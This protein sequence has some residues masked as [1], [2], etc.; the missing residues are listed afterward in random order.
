MLQSESK[1]RPGT[2]RQVAIEATNI[3][4][5]YPPSTKAV[6]NV[7]F[8]VHDGEVFGLLGPNGAGKTTTIKMITT[9]SKLTSGQITVFGNDVRTSPENVRSVLGYVPQGVSVDVDLT[10]YENLLIFAKLFYVDRKDRSGRIKE[11]LEYMGLSERANDLVKKF[12]GGMMRRLEIAQTL[13]NRPRI[14]FLDEPSIGLDPNSRLHVWESIKQLK[15]NYGTTIF[16]TTHDMN[17]A[18]ELCDRVA[19]MDSGKVA[20]LGKPEELK[21]SVGGDVVTVNLSSVP[22][23]LA[24]PKEIGSIIDQEGNSLQL[25]TDNGGEAVPLIVDFLNKQGIATLSVSVSRPGLDD[26]FMK[27]TKRRLQDEEQVTVTRSTRRAFMRHAG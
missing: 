8:T 5:F 6:D 2:Q 23:T 9:L 26:V 13:V 15:K 24:F 18:D 3:S 21:K 19:I 10:A 16:I 20:A 11:A 4:K 22:P 14:L 1:P 17:E 27:F 7:S 25:L 12:S